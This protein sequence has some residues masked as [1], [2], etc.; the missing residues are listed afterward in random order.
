VVNRSDSLYFTGEENMK[1]KR[2]KW[3]LLFCLPFVIVFLVFQLYP[4]IYSFYLSL[5]YQESNN[6]FTFIGFGNY[7]ELAQDKVFW[8]S[9]LN[10]WKIWLMCFIPQLIA[11][12]IL[13]VLLTQYHLKAAGFFRAVFY[14][15]NLVTAAS[16]GA[17]FL[18]MFSWQT[19]SVN[20]IL[21]ALGIIKEK[22]N[23]MSSP[24]FAQGITSFIQWWMWFGYSSIILTAGIAAIS[25]DVI[26]SSI[27]DGANSW[28]RLFKITLPLLRPT[29]VYVLVTSLIGGMQTFDIPMTLSKGSAEPNKSLMTMV[30]YLY[31][32][33]F[34][35]HDYPYG[36]TIS[37]GLFIIIVVFSLLFFRVMYGRKDKE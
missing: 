20:N 29:M 11:A 35:N 15:P 10:T 7:T 30:F 19:G 28:Q 33:A 2:A 17:L 16:I 24:A 13:A 34:R 4:I 1:K 27:V 21:L 26:E 36:A 37:Y 25:Q 31:N 3:G 9:V 5:T 18:A 6:T 23:W 12:L 32:M 14:L 22:V 8:K